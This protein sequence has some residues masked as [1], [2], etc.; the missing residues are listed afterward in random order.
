MSWIAHHLTAAAR[1]ESARAEEAAA[2]QRARLAAARAAA[3]AAELDAL[4]APEQDDKTRDAERTRNRINGWV[5]GVVNAA[6]ITGQP[7]DEAARAL[8]RRERIW[9]ADAEHDRLIDRIIEARYP[10]QRRR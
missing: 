4:T 10:N 1:V 8:I 6:K 3:R 2:A 7:V 5:A 9:R